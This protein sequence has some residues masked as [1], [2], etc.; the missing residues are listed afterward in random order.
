MNHKVPFPHTIMHR[1]YCMII[2]D[3]VQIQDFNYDLQG[4]YIYWSVQVDNLIPD[5]SITSI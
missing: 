3:I 4:Q 2:C 5:S 1:H